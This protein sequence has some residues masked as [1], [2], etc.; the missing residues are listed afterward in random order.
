MAAK[1]PC[2]ALLRDWKR[3]HLWPMKDT[4]AYYRR[5]IMKGPDPLVRLVLLAVTGRSS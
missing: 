3:K 4:P 2:A 1:S 5:V